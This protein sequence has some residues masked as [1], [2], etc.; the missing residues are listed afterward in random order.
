MKLVLE[1]SDLTK[2]VQEYLPKHYPE[3]QNK[4]VIFRWTVEEDP[5]FPLITLEITDKS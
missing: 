5:K 3:W 2:A 4:T 1:K